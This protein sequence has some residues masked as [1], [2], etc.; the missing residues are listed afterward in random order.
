MPSVPEA[1]GARWL[2]AGDALGASAVRT[3]PWVAMVRLGPQRGSEKGP[4]GMTLT[5]K[6]WGCTEGVRV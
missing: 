3:R 2:G 6:L 5:T 1:R 4:L